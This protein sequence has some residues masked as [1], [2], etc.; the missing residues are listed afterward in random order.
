MKF[1]ALIPA[2]NEEQTVGSVVQAC[3]ASGIIDEVIVISD[4][5]T[6]STAKVA[7]SSGAH[8]VIEL[9]K[10]MGKDFALNEGAQATDADYLLLLDAD[11]VGLKPEHVRQLVQP[12]REREA[13][14]TLGIFKKGSFHTDLAQAVTPFLSGQRVI[15]Y[16]IWS[17]AISNRIGV[18]FGLEV[19]LEKF[20]KSR[21]IKTKKVFLHGVSHRTKEEKLGMGKG[22]CFRLRMYSQILRVIFNKERRETG[23]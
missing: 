2:L 13:E 9:Q 6:D 8:R 16:Q 23:K 10:N 4:G 20:L 19:L 1:A 5:S 7:R 12:V 18:G 21:G 15:P 14:A 3:L 22:F 11:L 17:E